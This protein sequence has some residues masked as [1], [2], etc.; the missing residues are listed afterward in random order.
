MLPD[1]L[2]IVTN[3]SSFNKKWLYHILSKIKDYNLQKQNLFAH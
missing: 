1:R 2:Q 3:Y